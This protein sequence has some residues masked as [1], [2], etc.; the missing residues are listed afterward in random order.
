M[1]EVLLQYRR[2]R[3]SKMPKRSD[4]FSLRHPRCDRRVT[5]PE[6]AIAHIRISN[7]VVGRLKAGADDPPRIP[8]ISLDRIVRLKVRPNKT[9][10]CMLANKTNEVHRVSHMIKY[11]RA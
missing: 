6:S 10:R 9:R 1:I 7:F 3:E 11:S 2:R 5:S 8:Q 4:N